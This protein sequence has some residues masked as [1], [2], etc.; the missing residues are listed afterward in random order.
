MTNLSCSAARAS[1]RFNGFCR[2]AEA[3]AL[4]V[5]TLP[6]GQQFWV[7]PTVEVQRRFSKVELL[8]L[9]TIKEWLNVL[10]ITFREPSRCRSPPTRRL[11]ELAYYLMAR[12]RNILLDALERHAQFVFS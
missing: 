9:E 10:P 3:Q 7:A 4:E 8:A 6:A 2:T 1:E 5:L 11:N 12:R